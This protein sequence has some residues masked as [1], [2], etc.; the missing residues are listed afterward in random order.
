MVKQAFKSKFNDRDTGGEDDNKNQANK[1]HRVKKDKLE[2]KKK[3]K[4]NK[5]KFHEIRSKLRLIK[6]SKDLLRKMGVVSE[7]FSQKVHGD[8]I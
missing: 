5:K 8:E 4:K 2:A 3:F 7:R 1:R 6:K